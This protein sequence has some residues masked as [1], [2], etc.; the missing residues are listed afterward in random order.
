MF[1]ASARPLVVIVGSLTMC[2]ENRM[3]TDAS[4]SVASEYATTAMCIAMDEFASRW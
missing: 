3:R 4:A 1:T 2:A